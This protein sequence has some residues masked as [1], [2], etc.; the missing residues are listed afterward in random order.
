[1][2]WRAGG[3]FSFPSSAQN[4]RGDVA[5]SGASRQITR[6]KPTCLCFVLT[7][8]GRLRTHPRNTLVS[9]ATSHT[10][11]TS[12]A[13]PDTTDTNPG[14]RKKVAPDVHPDCSWGTI[15]GSSVSTATCLRPHRREI[16]LGKIIKSLVFQRARYSS[17]Q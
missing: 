15:P 9:A 6:H 1:M 17:C 2:P 3:F 4:A 5:L 16:Y 11:C 14:P 13:Q 8:H 10:P 12:G 7:P